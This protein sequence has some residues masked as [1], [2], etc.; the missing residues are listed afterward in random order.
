MATQVGEAVIK[1]TFDGKEVKSSL[2]KTSS[3]IEQTGKKSGNAFGEAWTV[4]AGALIAKGISKISSMIS[5]N[6][7]K[8]ISRVD[9]INN[10]PK[11][12][13]ALGYSSEEA[14]NSIG[15]I[16]D[17]LDGLPTSLD[18]A[19]SD[20]QKLAATMGNLDKG[21]VNAT[22]VSIALNNMFLAGG[23][24]T[25]AASNAMEQYNQM[26][27]AGKAD[28]QSW[29]SMLDA[30]PGQL[31]Q[32]AKTLLGATA[33]QEDLRQALNDGTISFDQL[34]E[35]IVKLNTEG[36]EGFA[37]FEEQARSATG[38]IGTAL[39]NVQNRI[40]KAMAKIIDHIGSEKI[41]S[42]INDISSHFSE[43]ADQVV[44]AIDFIVEHW[45]VIG[46]ILGVLGSI[47][48]IVIGINLAL[49]AYHKVMTAINAVQK[50]FGVGIKVVSSGFE[51]VGNVLNKS[52]IAKNTD[53]IGSSFSS[54]VTTIQNAVTKIGQLAAS[55]VNALMEPVKAALKGIGQAIAGF[56]EAFANP[57]ILMGALMFAAAAAAIAAAILLIGG[58]IGVVT[59]ALEALFNKVILPVC[60][61]IV[62]TVLKL[63]DALT[64]AI[65]KL[66]NQAFIPLGNFLIGAF[67][68][69][70]ESITNTIT[71][72][73]Q[74]ALVPLINALSG[75]FTSVLRTV[76]DI[77]TGIVE[78]ALRG[79]A[80]IIEAIGDGFLKM[81]QAIEAA[82]NGVSGILNAFAN[83]I[84]AIGQAVVAI[85]ALATGRSINYGYGYAHLFA[86][87]GRVYGPGTETSDSIPARLS[88]GEYVIR[89][90]SAKAIGYDNLDDMNETGNLPAAAVV[91]NWA[92]ALAQSLAK[93]NSTTGVYGN[94]PINVY[95]TNEISN[96]MDAADIGR[97]LMESI[98]RSA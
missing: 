62:N 66:T 52:G 10:F 47:A 34:N 59:P 20:V 79:L 94:R 7:G 96:D 46:P 87:G 13:T 95:M 32:L 29:R 44:L 75:A 26:L 65:I 14:S 92:G 63:I 55:L 71:N 97:K 39:E 98:R 8:A 18:S 6:L 86:E 78:G 72:L 1:L 43:M 74:G 37:S 51:S 5:N 76:G 41:A 31:K 88:A 83:I 93:E 48:G 11:V 33:T 68:T 42:V 84:M 30:A 49:K 3:Q 70:L 15:K 27:A 35:A 50:I 23:K 89:A 60:N 36:G 58:A 80:A 53:A 73:T 91:Y 19:V 64:N 69:I 85:V 21:M 38:G 40:A 45:N 2:E 25:E 57:S 17:A 16:S 81:G 54:L 56:F 90:E 82:L 77:I 67:K 12:M 28:M 22:S 61:F 4:A 24:G 9:T